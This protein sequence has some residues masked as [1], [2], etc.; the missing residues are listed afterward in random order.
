MD[1]GGHPRRKRRHITWDKLRRDAADDDP[2]LFFNVWDLANHLQWEALQRFERDQ[3]EALERI[4]RRRIEWVAWAIR[5]GRR[6]LIPAINA[7]LDDM[8][9]RHN[10]RRVPRI[11][12]QSGAIPITAEDQRW[13]GE[14]FDTLRKI[15]NA[16]ERGRL[17]SKAPTEA[18]VL[19]RA[20]QLRGTEKRPPNEGAPNNRAS[21]MTANKLG[22]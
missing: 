8:L 22:G 13:Y 14:D 11:P 9:A 5:Q 7:E 15:Y 12:G 4:C 19:E 16:D 20:A 2:P 17:L 6:E 10:A 3:R 18:D 1:A 21:L